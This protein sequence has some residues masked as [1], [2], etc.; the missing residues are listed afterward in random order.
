MGEI[1]TEPTKAVAGRITKIYNFQ[2]S[3]M[4]KGSKIH[5]D[6]LRWMCG[7]KSQLCLILDMLPVRSKTLMVIAT[8]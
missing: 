2:L 6:A 7:L 1:K 3:F 5:L 8:I 4:S